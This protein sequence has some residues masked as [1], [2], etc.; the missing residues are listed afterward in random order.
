[1]RTLEQYKWVEVI[2]NTWRHNEW[3]IKLIVN[4]FC[5]FAK[6]RSDEMWQ[7]DKLGAEN[8]DEIGEKYIFYSIKKE[9]FKLECFTM[10]L[11]HMFLKLYGKYTRMCLYGWRP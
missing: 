3:I 10:S 11:E 4:S 6:S 9:K 1:M 8:C 7:T 5:A 2:K